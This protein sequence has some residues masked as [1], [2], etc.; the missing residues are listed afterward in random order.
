MKSEGRNPKAEIRPKSEIRSECNGSPAPA[1]NFGKTVTDRWVRSPAGRKKIAHRFER[2]RA[3]ADEPLA[4][5]GAK[6]DGERIP[7]AFQSSLAGL[8]RY[9]ALFPTLERV[10][11]CRTSL[12]DEDS[13]PG[14]ISNPRGTVGISRHPTGARAGFSRSLR[15]VLITTA[16]IGFGCVCLAGESP[17]QPPAE[18]ATLL[19]ANRNWLLPSI[20]SRKGMV[21]EY[22]QEEP[23]RERVWFDRAGNMM[24]RLEASKE[25]PEHTSRQSVWLADGRSYR[26]EANDRFI[27]LQPADPKGADKTWI[28]RDRL[29]QHLAMG[30]ALDCALTRLARD[31]ESFRVETRTVPGKPG[32]YLLVLRPIG[33]ARLFT[34]TMLVFT[35][36]AYMH[37]V[38]YERSDVVCDATTHRPLAEKDYG[39]GSDLTGDYVFE[40][41]LEDASGP[42]PGRIRAVVPYKKDGK[43]QS[44]EMLAQFRFAKPGV[45]LL[46]R[47]ESHFRGEGGGS[48]G[49]VQVVST[50]ANDF[51]EI[52]RVLEQAK[53]TETLLSTI[54]EA[55][56]A[57][58]ASPVPGNDWTPLI[59]RPAWTEEARKSADEKNNQPL[60]GLYRARMQHNP[61]GPAVLEFEG[62]SAVPWKQFLTSWT[63]K[64]QD[65]RGTVLGS[66]STNLNVRAESGP[67]PF[68]FTVPVSVSANSA[69]P[70]S[71]A[72]TGTVERMTGMYH[73]HGMWMTL[74][75]GK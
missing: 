69:S 25:S 48:T 52:A 12:R 60:L 9:R 54:R 35:S 23:Y 73:G 15:A 17:S 53:S 62:V 4:P 26:G 64:L 57:M 2:W 59:L 31:P 3:S 14:S 36:W 20:E 13:G 70:K 75:S 61:S 68:A 11:Y 58:S 22:R 63:V 6:E 18:I 29:P 72:I 30:L 40:N 21:Y 50:S 32:Q 41:W 49:T 37:D 42:A 65:E 28:E 67:T 19:N 5:S 47:V 7:R 71:V 45:W 43:D 33:R 66:A 10:G 56:E 38:G 39:S 46:Q 55:P 27:Q 44:L 34:G 16:T 24:A 74:T 1:I 8:L 51:P